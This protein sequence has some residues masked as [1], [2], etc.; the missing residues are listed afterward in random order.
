MIR[1]DRPA[2]IPR[3]F[4]VGGD[5]FFQNVE[6]LR[7][8]L[9][10]IRQRWDNRLVLENG[11][12]WEAYFDGGAEIVIHGNWYTGLDD[13]HWA[14]RLPSGAAVFHDYA[15]RPEVDVVDLH[16]RNGR[17]E[18]IVL[19]VVAEAGDGPK[20]EVRIPARF[21]FFRDKFRGLGEGLMYRRIGAG[22]F[23][24][25]PFFRKG[26]VDLFG[27]PDAQDG[28]VHP[29]VESFPEII[30]GVSQDRAKVLF[31]W[32]FGPVGQCKTIRI[33]QQNVTPMRPIADLIQI[34]AQGGRVPHN[35][36]D[37]AFG[38]FDL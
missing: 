28:I 27:V 3:S 25:F 32:L 36:I 21:Y 15:A 18:I 33:S 11:S 5:E 7:D 17:Q 22:G 9:G 20:I 4:A 16:D 2:H 6:R 13:C 26:E 12:L 30:D 38:P 23:K 14:V 10:H 31:D 24:I 8:D 1:G 35:R 37:V 19:V 29:V 34:A